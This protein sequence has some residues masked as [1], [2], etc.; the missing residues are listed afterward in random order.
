MPRPQD[1]ELF[2]NE[3][4]AVLRDLEPADYEWLARHL[5]EV[6]LRAGEVLTPANMRPSH[7]YFPQSGV[8]S[9]VA[10]FSDGSS[11]EVG[12]VGYEGFVGIAAF[13]GAD[14]SPHKTMVQIDAVLRRIPIQ[15]FE[16]ALEELPAFDRILRR[17]VDA[18]LYQ[19]GQSAACN[20]MHD[21]GTRAARW[22]LMTHDRVGTD[23]F[24]LTHEFLAMMLGVRRAGVSEA[25][26]EMQRRGAIRYSRGRVTVLDR[27]LL[28]QLSCECYGVIRERFDK[29]L[30]G[31]ERRVEPVPEPVFAHRAAAD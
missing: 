11:V 29:M 7:I 19:V 9:H 12:T 27:R 17:S 3:R 25:A 2:T 14:S 23:T 24:S 31:T 22:L 1:T 16:A 21:L 6:D 8:V 4:N 28:E 18:Y 20:R 10:E 15:L 30:R 5:E 13:L 26:A